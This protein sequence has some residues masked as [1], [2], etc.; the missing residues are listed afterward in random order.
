MTHGREP[1]GAA[2][3]FPLIAIPEEPDA[4]I[5]RPGNRG[6]QK[7]AWNSLRLPLMRPSMQRHHRATVVSDTTEPTARVVMRLVGKRRKSGPHARDEK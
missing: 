2:G 7:R 6:Q 1:D 5:S 4:A 3:N